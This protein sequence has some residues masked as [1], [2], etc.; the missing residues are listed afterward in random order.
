LNQVIKALFES[1]SRDQGI[2]VASKLQKSKDQDSR[3]Q[4]DL[5]PKRSRERSSEQAQFFCWSKIL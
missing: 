2:K 4:Y 3:L 5:W 1:R